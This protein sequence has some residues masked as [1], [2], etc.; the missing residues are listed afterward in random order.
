MLQKYTNTPHLISVHF[1]NLEIAMINEDKWAY[2][3]DIIDMGSS[4]LHV[5]RRKR[6]FFNFKLCFANISQDISA[7]ICVN[8]KVLLVLLPIHGR[9]KAANRKHFLCLA[10]QSGGLKCVWFSFVC[11]LMIRYCWF[12]QIRSLVSHARYGLSSY[13]KRLICKNGPHQYSIEQRMNAH[14]M[15]IYEFDKIVRI[16]MCLYSYGI[17]DAPFEWH[18]MS[19][20][21]VKPNPHTHT[22]TITL[23]RVHLKPLATCLQTHHIQSLV[24]IE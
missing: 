17:L 24:D 1:L 9:E 22:H 10:R 18:L 14:K 20:E 4:K 12:W 6:T 11:K 13:S 21:A 5:T 15:L 2:W 23:S 19:L 3:Y 8:L 7:L 16:G